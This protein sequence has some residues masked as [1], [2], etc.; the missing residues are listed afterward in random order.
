[1]HAL[2]IFDHL[3]DNISP[4]DAQNPFRM[5]SIFPRKNSQNLFTKSFSSWDEVITTS[6]NLLLFYVTFS[7]RFQSRQFCSNNSPSYIL[8]AVYLSVDT[9]LRKFL[10]KNSQFG[11]SHFSLHPPTFHF[12]IRSS[13]VYHSVFIKSNWYCL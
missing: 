2:K 12:R 8:E 9:F 4:I 3:I 11:L 5:V 10:L 6:L 13:L 1:M 7:I